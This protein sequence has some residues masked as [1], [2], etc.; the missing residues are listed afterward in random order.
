MSCPLLNSLG[1]TEILKSVL[2]FRYWTCCS[3]RQMF[4]LRTFSGEPPTFGCQRTNYLF[5]YRVGRDLVQGSKTCSAV[6]IPHALSF[7]DLKDG[8]CRAIRSARSRFPSTTRFRSLRKSYRMIMSIALG[9]SVRTTTR[10]ASFIYRRW[11][12]S[13]VWL[14]SRLFWDTKFLVGGMRLGRSI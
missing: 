3:F 7:P 6:P 5:H 13:C 2:G 12:S 1:D 14:R 9:A 10:R 4:Y 8:V 11:L